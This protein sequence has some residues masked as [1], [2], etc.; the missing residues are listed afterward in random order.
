MDVPIE[1]AELELR[2]TFPQEGK[3]DLKE[4]VGVAM[5]KLTYVL[6]IASGAPPPE[7]RAVVQRAE[8]ACH[9][10][11]SLRVSIRVEPTLRLNGQELA[12]T[13]P[14]PPELRGPRA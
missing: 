1:K 8:A 2:A 9:A 5:E 13:P 12:V 14:E 10:E 3:Y 7:V 11:N 4:G 6:D